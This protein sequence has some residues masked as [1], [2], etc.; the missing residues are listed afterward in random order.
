M[1]SYVKTIV[2]TILVY[3]MILSM[4]PMSVL[5]VGALDITLA[6]DGTADSPYLITN[7]DEF[8]YAMN[9]YGNS[10][11]VHY[12]L[13]SDILVSNN[14]VPEVFKGEFNGN[15]HSINTDSRFAIQNNGK[16]YNLY[17][18]YSQPT[19]QANCFCMTNNGEI[20]GVMAYAEVVSVPDGAIFCATNNGT[21]TGCATL[22]SIAVT[23]DGGS[24]SS[25]FVLSNTSTGTISNCYS[26]ATVTTEGNANSYYYEYNLKYGLS[27]SS[28]GIENSYY[29]A[30]VAGNIGPNGLTTEYMKSQEFVDLLN[31]RNTSPYMMWTADSESVNNGYPIPELAY[32]AAIKS[33]KTN[34]SIVDPEYV[35]L[36]VDDGGEIYYTLD[37]SD[38]DINSIKYTEPIFITDTIVIKAVG[39]K[40]G[41]SGI[42]SQFSY[43]KLK[44]EGTESSPYQI[45]CEAALLSIPE[46]S[47]SASYVL[48]NDIVLY[49]PFTSLGDFYGVLDGNG[50]T[51][52]NLYN[53]LPY[54]QGKDYCKGLFDNNYGLIQNLN[55]SIAFQPLPIRIME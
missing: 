49:E 48:T 37:G 27:Q 31:T 5:S 8:A 15:F 34:H 4:L 16:I 42:I 30:T 40:E 45:D 51:I 12:L 10:E 21:I 44:G 7:A 38:P 18:R 25:G 14:T 9:T 35:S 32:N 6:G 23:Q 52:S 17:Y 13:E 26:A 50:H 33:S 22:G 46:V 11:G 39:Y 53:K 20:S 19:T 24:I 3:L 29:D 41:V 2:A 1:K 55:I 28:G 47:L 36:S 54:Y 43:A